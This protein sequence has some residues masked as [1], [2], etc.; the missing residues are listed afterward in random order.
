MIWRGLGPGGACVK[1]GTTGAGVARFGSKIS[2]LA[3]FFAL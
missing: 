3:G 2:R 1:P